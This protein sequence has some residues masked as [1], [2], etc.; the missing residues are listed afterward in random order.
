M[1]IPSQDKIQYEALR[2]LTDNIARR[3]ADFI[4]PLAK[5]FEL[6]EADLNKEY[7]SGNGLIFADR[8]SWALSYLN[9]SGVATRPKR[10]L[11]KITELGHE[12]S[13]DP[14]RFKEHVKRKYKEWEI[15]EK[16]ESSS[17]LDI[18]PLSDGDLTPEEIL[19]SSYEEIKNSI[20]EEILDT[21]LTKTPREFEKLVVS[22]LQKMGYGGEITNSAV[23]TPY[24]HDKGVDGIIKEDVLGFGTICIQA[25]RNTYDNPVGR[26]AVQKFV[27]ALMQAQSTKGVFITTSEFT[28]GALEFAQQLSSNMKI[29]LIDGKKLASYIYEYSLGMQTEQFIEIKKL[30]GDFW[31]NLQDEGDN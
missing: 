12:L 1:A 27:G 18:R 20:Y 21:I 31:D 3:K 11:Y 13:T 26:D 9:R 30:D 16:K 25:K 28:R 5:I 8:I 2:L 22:L 6:T 29:I 15:T 10:G 14:V 4:T 23:V 7:D 17:T 24:S 19:Y